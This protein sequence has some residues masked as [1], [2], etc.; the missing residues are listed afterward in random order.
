MTELINKSSMHDLK[1]TQLDVLRGQFNLMMNPSLPFSRKIEKFANQPVAYHLHKR[2]DFLK[3][4]VDQE[5][6]MDRKDE[7]LFQKNM[8][9][10]LQTDSIERTIDELE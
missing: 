3:R 8:K 1:Q 2:N 9:K 7:R 10:I 5:K 4:I 6:R